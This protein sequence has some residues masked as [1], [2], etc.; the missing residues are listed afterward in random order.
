MIPSDL[1][2]LLEFIVEYNFDRRRRFL[3]LIASENVMSPLAQAVYSCDMTSRYGGEASGN[4]VLD[5]KVSSLIDLLEN[6][7]R[8]IMFFDKLDARVLSGT[9]ANIVVVSSLCRRGDS[10][11][12]LK[13]EDGGHPSYN[14]DGYPGILGLKHE[15]LPFSTEEFNVDIDKALATIEKV[16]PR[17]IFLGASA[18]LFQHP[19]KEICN[20][21]KS[22]GSIVVYDASHVLGLITGGVWRNPLEDGADIL[23]AS[24][25]KTF[26]GPQGG[27]IFFNSREIY[28]KV[29]S[30]IYP[31]F[32]S[33]IHLHRIPA[34]IVTAVEMRVFGQRYAMQIIRNAKA[35]AESLCEFGFKLAGESKGFTNSHQILIYADEFGGGL[36]T[37]LKLEKAGIIVDSYKI[38]GGSE[39]V[40]IGVQELTR[41]GMREED[42]MEIAWFF[43]NILI[44]DRDPCEVRRKVE[45]FR[46]M[47]LKVKY[48]FDIPDKYR[49][50]STLFMGVDFG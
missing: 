26:P 35:L 9:M 42:M 25:H 33:N 13:T 18:Y 47:F 32:V 23:T 31:K 44:D 7:F 2:N 17:I 46:R 45:E 15:P 20:T 28:E 37:S 41:I 14:S 19:V 5:E 12:S 27:V 50:V 1:E 11:V 8:K 3:N 43:K 24:T 36:K 38:P 29:S 39:G 4:R 48:G 22:V 30:T 21:A 16:K 6:C 10:I 34:T 49:S 40:R